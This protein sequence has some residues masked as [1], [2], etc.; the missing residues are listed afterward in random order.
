MEI[1][2]DNKT[3]STLWAHLQL[4]PNN[5][6]HQR[7]VARIYFIQ[8]DF[9][10]DLKPMNLYTK[11]VQR[12]TIGRTLGSYELASEYVSNTT[13]LYLARGHLTAKADYVLAAHQLATFYYI[14]VAPQWQS[15]N[16]GNWLKVEIG[17]KKFIEKRNVDTEVY[18]GTHGHCTL[19]DT[20]NRQQPLFLALN[21]QEG[22]NR[23]PVP[24]LY[25]KMIIAESI[26]AGIVLIGVNNPYVS[27]DSIEQYVVCPDISD[28][29][30]YIDWDRKNV[31][32]GYSYACSVSDFIKT[33]KTLPKLPHIKNLLI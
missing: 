25:Y 30:N 20:K 32:A 17:I 11:Y 3:G 4:K 22:A 21:L 28:Q 10:P 6:Y 1:C 13:E 7:N 8:G 33:V 15:F 2:H 16:N 9:Y 26:D 12:Q 5:A 14:N 31:T 29:V 23:I 27:I 24:L 19:P 18:T